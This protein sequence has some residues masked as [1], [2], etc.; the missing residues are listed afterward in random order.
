MQKQ[1]SLQ[2]KKAIA[3]GI[4]AIALAC[5]AIFI[6]ALLIHKEIIKNTEN[7]V[8]TFIILFFCTTLSGHIATRGI[9]TGKWRFALISGAIVFTAVIALTLVLSDTVFTLES[10]I[11]IIAVAVGSLLGC[12]F[13]AKSTKKKRKKTMIYNKK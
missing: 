4:I 5:I 2:T 9:K 7:G 12:I 10:F 11:N 3:A 1:I 8:A 13:C 6:T